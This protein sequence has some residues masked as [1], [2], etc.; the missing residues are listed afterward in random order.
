VCVGGGAGRQEA[1]GVGLLRRLRSKSDVE[2][3]L[4]RLLSGGKESAYVLYIKY[5]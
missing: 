5:V 2:Q 1:G 4:L 3:M